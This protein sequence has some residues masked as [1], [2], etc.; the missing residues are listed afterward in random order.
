MQITEDV[1]AHKSA[2]IAPVVAGVSWVLS[3]EVLNTVPEK[4]AKWGFGIAGLISLFA[5]Q[6]LKKTS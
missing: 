1:K 4:Y 3:P 6:L 5:P 2:F